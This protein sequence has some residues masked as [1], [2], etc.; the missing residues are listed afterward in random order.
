[1]R[2][3]INTQP[4]LLPENDE[5]VLRE[6]SISIPSGKEP[7]RID[8]FISRQVADMTR[9][10]AAELIAEG[11]VKVND[12]IV[13]PSHKVKA[14]EF[15]HMLI[16]SKPPL[17]VG[18]EDIPLEILYQDEW[19]LVI[20][21]P[22]NMVTHPARGNRSGTL[23]NA[24]LGHFGELA[25][26]DDPDR[27]GLVHRLDK[28]TTGVIVVCRR[29][30]AM[31]RLSEMF[32]NRTIE[33]E[34]NAIVWWKM[35]SK[36]GTVNQPIGRDPHNRLI[37]S[38]QPDGKIAITHW[39]VLESFAFMSLLSLKL[40]TGRTHQ[41]RVHLSGIG[42]PV[43]GDYDYSGRNRQFGKLSSMQRSVAADYLEKIDRQMLHAKTLG[44]VH[45]VTKEYLRF[46][47][48]LPDDM[49]WLLDRLRNEN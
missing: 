21:K 4:I 6:I 23:V 9:T 37:Y 33:R 49:L 16:P 44:F 18:A 5:T 26:S 30:P 14:G 46:E 45:P 2:I 31:S 29:E 24:L 11:H 40:E 28:D 41:I 42:N 1:M 19:L 20:N 15:L 13:K 36:K 8:V 32:R 7:E 10:K 34:Y 12:K 35:K 25:Q 3:D 22:P 47:S 43:F 38:I 48:P 17:L 27:P 39:T